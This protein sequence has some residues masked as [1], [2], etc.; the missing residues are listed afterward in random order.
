MLKPLRYPFGCAGL[1]GRQA[2]IH[3]GADVAQMYKISILCVT[4]EIPRHFNLL[5]RT[6]SFKWRGEQC[7][8]E[9]VVSLKPCKT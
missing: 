9:M 2:G 3:V 8:R 7:G 4:Y 5:G 1:G 6:Q